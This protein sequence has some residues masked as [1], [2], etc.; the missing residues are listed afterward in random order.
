MSL[1]R[2]LPFLVVAAAIVA[3]VASAAPTGDIP[4]EGNAYIGSDACLDCHESADMH[5]DFNVHMRIESFEVQGREVGCEGCHGPGKLHMEESDP[6]LIRSFA[7]EEGYGEKVCMECHATKNTNWERGLSEWPISTHAVEGVECQTCHPMHKAM[8]P[9]P[10]KACVECHPDTVAQMQLPSHH[11]VRE[12]KMNCASCHNPHNGREF[13][14]KTRMRKADLCYKCHQA[15]EGP[16]VFEHAPVE[17][18][19][20]I[21][22]A[23]HGS[24]ANNLLV[25]NEPTLCLQCHDFHFHAGY[26]SS[27]DDVVDVGGFERENPFGNQGMNIAFTTECTGCHSHIHGSDTPSQTT[28]GRGQGLIP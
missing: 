9:D 15:I 28:P 13:M 8:T 25:A 12:G 2:A 24:V 19:C 26:K 14:L 11:P 6:E 18:D 3:G 5:M 10:N 17:E 1:R 27:D 21:C 4:M 23:P 20:G 22:H 16:W 7:A